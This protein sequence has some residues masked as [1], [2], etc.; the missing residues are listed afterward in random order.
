MIPTSEALVISAL[1]I[2]QH[3]LIVR[4]LRYRVQ[5]SAE[6]DLKRKHS[7]IKMTFYHF[8]PKVSHFSMII[9]QHAYH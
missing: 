9:E 6:A 3:D 4:T 5:D 1:L 7:Y 8:M 2:R